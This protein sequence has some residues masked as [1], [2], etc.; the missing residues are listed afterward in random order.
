MHNI[1]LFCRDNG[2]T[3]NGKP[4]YH[5]FPR[6]LQGS[7]SS[8]KNWAGK[9]GLEFEVENNFLECIILNDISRRMNGA[10]K[11]CQVA[12]LEPSRQYYIQ[13]DMRMESLI[14]VITNNTIDHGVISVPLGFTFNSNNYRITNVAKILPPVTKKGKTKKGKAKKPNLVVG[15]YYRQV[16]GSSPSMY[17]GYYDVKTVYDTVGK[18][19][20]NRKMHV[21][22]HEMTAVTF[23][24]GRG[25]LPVF[26]L[27]V[28]IPTCIISH[29]NHRDYSKYL[30]GQHTSNRGSI[31][32]YA[33]K[34][35]VILDSD[36]KLVTG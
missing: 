36:N 2:N 20:S 21:F 17:L 11:I 12:M 27:F 1:K 8:A 22:V 9:D 30:T 15:E 4:L 26:D 25:V 32:S 18:N 33:L 6:P 28:G 19:Y 16:Y 35:Y 14:D 23:T 31:G 24:G 10:S 5:A 29:D 3:L 7:H 13:V 34:G